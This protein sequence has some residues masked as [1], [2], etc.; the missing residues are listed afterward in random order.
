MFYPEK[1]I[2]QKILSFGLILLLL[3][4][5]LLSSSAY[6]AEYSYMDPFNVVIYCGKPDGY[7]AHAYNANYDRNTYLSLTDLSAALNGTERQFSFSYE[8][9]PEDGEYFQ[10][11]ENEPALSHASASADA[12]TEQV[13]LEFRRNRLFLNDD[14]KKYYT[15]RDGFNDLYMSLTDIQLMFNM[16]ITFAAEDCIY[17]YPDQVF[18][19]DLTELERNGYFDYLNGVVLGDATTGEIFFR[20]DPNK[21]TSIASTSKLMSYL[22]IAEAMKSGAFRPDSP[23]VISESAEKLSKSGDG[24]IELTAGTEIPVSE[25]LEAML[26]ASSNESALALAEYSY[27]SEEAFVHAMNAKAAE[28]GLNSAQ[29]F[30]CHGLPTYSLNT[31]QTKRQ[32]RMN[33]S[34]LFQLSA[35]IL[36]YFP[37]ITDITSKTYSVLPNLLYAT[38]NSNPLIFNMS[39]VNGLK[40]GSTNRAGYCLVASMPLSVQGETHNILLVLL[41]AETASERGQEAEIL[42]RYAENIALH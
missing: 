33:A 7:V 16:Q 37:E 14:E 38:A 34:D 12:H 28:L 17:I 40:T 27:G 6:A 29:F 5:L 41:G 31:V 8:N 10:V 39:N 20:R 13:W 18:Q 2:L 24:M 32:N 3:F 35:Y 36:N 15:Y 11:T 19:P 21:V 1:S 4:P 22:L 26:V 25:L 30:N 23:V 9:T 42:L